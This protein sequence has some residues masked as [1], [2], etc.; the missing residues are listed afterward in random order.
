MNLIEVLKNSKNEPPKKQLVIL[1]VNPIIDELTRNPEWIYSMLKVEE[2]LKITIIYENETENF[3]QSLFYEK[4]VS[5]HRI[6]FD[7]LQTYRN[8]LIGS[9]GKRNTGFCEDVLNLFNSEEKELYSSRLILY[10]NNLRH[11]IN[12][13]LIDDVI[14]YSFTTLDIPTLDTYTR[15][16]KK[17]NSSLYKQL[18]DYISFLL[19][20]ESG[21]IFLSKSGNELI[22]LYD[23][24]SIPRGIYPRKAF[25]STD[26]QRYSIWAF[27]FNRK[28]ELLLH[29]RSEKTK[30]NRLLW[31]KSAGGHVDLTDSST[32]ITAKRELVEELFL[33]EAEYT[34]YMQAELGDIIDF[35][36]WNIDKRPEKHFKSSFD[37]LDDADWVVFR[38]SD[39]DERGGSSPMTIR[40]KSPRKIHVEIDG[41]ERVETWHTRFISDVY[42]FVAPEGYIDTKEQMNELFELAE[43]RGAAASHKLYSIEDLIED[44]ERNP[45][46]YT[47]DMIYMCSEK[48]WVLLQFSESIKY[49][50]TREK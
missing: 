26:Y 12:V 18:S 24:G 1:G 37:G 49:I 23:R 22:E 46:G 25:Y 16:T 14:L 9:G 44:V 11:N 30:D 34:K 47:D 13:I 40:R 42:L 27:V 10:Q 17:S 45:E 3:N 19:N 31:D 4:G 2:N 21:S 8:R 36:E 29:K 48:K 43:K 39:K 35:G 20:K 41:V 6:E 33:P 5:K 15:I 50:F 7:K 32:L 28:G 38:A